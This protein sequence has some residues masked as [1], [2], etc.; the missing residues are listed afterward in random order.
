MSSWEQNTRGITINNMTLGE[1]SRACK[2][3]PCGLKST[4]LVSA[5]VTAIVAAV[6]CYYFLHGENNVK[7]MQENCNAL[8]AASNTTEFCSN[9]TLYDWQFWKDNWTDPVAAKEYNRLLQNCDTECK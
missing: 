6:C 3:E 1:V 2:A 9:T 4:K 8:L 7:T 5:L